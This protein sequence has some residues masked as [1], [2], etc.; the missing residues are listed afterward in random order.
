MTTLYAKDFKCTRCPARK[1]QAEVFVGGN[2]PDLPQF[3]M[4]KEHAEEWWIEV[5]LRLSGG[6]EEVKIADVT[7]KVAKALRKSSKEKT[8]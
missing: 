2:D 3:P 1:R 4:C 7:K 5:M 6:F 8:P